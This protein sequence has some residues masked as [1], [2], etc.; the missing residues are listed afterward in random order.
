MNFFNNLWHNFTTENTEFI[1]NFITTPGLL[2]EITLSML[3]FS[4]LFNVK[5]SK[6]RKIIYIILCYIVGILSTNLIPRPYNAFVNYV[7]TFIFIMLVFKTSFT[8]TVLSMVI[9]AFVMISLNTLFLNPFLRLF[10][11]N[12]IQ[13]KNV[14]LYRT[15]FLFFI[16][17]LVICLIIF[18]KKKNIKISTFDNLDKKSLLAIN[19]NFFF[20]LLSICLVVV[21]LNH[22]INMVPIYITILCFLCLVSFSFINIYSLIKAVKLNEAAIKIQSMEDQNKSLSD[23]YDKVKGF[24]HDFQNIANTIGGYIS[25]DDMDGLKKYYSSLEIDFNKTNN[26]ETLTP[27]LVNNPGIYS[28]LNAKFYKADELNIRINLEYLININEV[29][30]NIYAF[31]RMLG[32][33]LDNAIEAAKNCKEKIINIKFRN[34]FNNNRHVIIVE[35]TYTNKN[36]NID[37]IFEKGVS[38]K[39]NH[40]GLGLYEIRKYLKKTKNINLFTSKTEQYFSQ[41]LEIYYPATETSNSI[42]TYNSHSKQF[43]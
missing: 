40:S 37:K 14:A 34:E 15:S 21:V 3:L 8:K 20:C 2:I 17:S 10:H 23:L 9:P 43:S 12:Y 11:I 33:L 5:S 16:Y 7:A 18:L 41:Q 29:N 42:I 31:S 19:L 1:H 27:N 25:T 38:E 24:K 22:F 39:E 30:V 35:N 6:K 28:L 26:M 13:F 4:T 32:I 36:V